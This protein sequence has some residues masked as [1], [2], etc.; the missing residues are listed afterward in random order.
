M[1]SANTAL[2]REREARQSAYATAVADRDALPADAEPHT[3]RKA[4]GRVTMA[5]HAIRQWG[6]RVL[7]NDSHSAALHGRLTPVANGGVAET[8]DSVAAR[9]L[10]SDRVPGIGRPNVEVD[11]I[12]SRITAA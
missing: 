5:L 3:V 4:Q 9:I 1:T 6:E 11:A 7:E 2:I 12:A 8:A 10:A